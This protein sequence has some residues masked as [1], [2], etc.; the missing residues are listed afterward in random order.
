MLGPDKIASVV[1]VLIVPVWALGWPLL[2]LGALLVL[3]LA[4]HLWR[5][6]RAAASAAAAA[7]MLGLLAIW[8]HNFTN[9]A[10]QQCGGP[11]ALPGRFYAC[12]APA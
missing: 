10:P 11:N 12:A 5:R 3:S 6:R 1:A 4:I 2:A 9:P 7:L 8:G